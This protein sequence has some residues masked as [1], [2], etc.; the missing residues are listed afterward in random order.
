MNKDV[1]SE[2]LFHIESEVDQEVDAKQLLNQVT[3]TEDG[4]R[5]RV[6]GSVLEFNEDGD[7]L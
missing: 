4:Y 2:I 5:L 6:Y 1:E 7:L 3:K